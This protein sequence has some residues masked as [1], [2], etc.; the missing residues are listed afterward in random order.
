MLVLLIHLLCCPLFPQVL[1]I[2]RI[3]YYYTILDRN[4]PCPVSSKKLEYVNFKLQT[5]FMSEPAVLYW[6]F[7]VRFALFV[8]V[9]RSNCVVSR[10]LLRSFFRRLP[11]ARKMLVYWKRKRN[12]SINNRLTTECL[13]ITSQRVRVDLFALCL[14]VFECGSIDVRVMV[15]FV[16]WFCVTN[17]LCLTIRSQTVRVDLFAIYLCVELMYLRDFHSFVQ[18]P[19]EPTSCVI[20]APVILLRGCSE[21]QLHWREN[22]RKMLN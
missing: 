3:M 21:T 19:S 14:L 18:D 13:K 10:S 11:K 16:R 17:R 12:P 20:L 7:L 8:V 15:S 9:L 2:A 5:R 22:A 1:R 4:T 6:C